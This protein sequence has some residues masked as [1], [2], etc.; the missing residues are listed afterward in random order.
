MVNRN[1]IYLSYGNESEYRRTIFSILSYFSWCPDLIASTR[2]ILYTDAPEYFRSF[3]SEK[4]IE[5]C[6]LSPELLTEMKGPE[7]FIHR[8]KVMVINLSFNSYPNEDQLF[9][10]S[11]TFFT[12][13]ATEIIDTI[14]SGSSLMHVREYTIQDSLRIFSLFKQSQ[15][16]KSFLHYISSNVFRVGNEKISFD[17]RAYSWNSGVLGLH[18]DF[19]MYMPDVVKLTD[20]FYA[21]SK[22]FISE[23]LAFSFILQKTTVISAAKKYITHYWGRRQK[24]LIE[25]LLSSIFEEK[26]KPELKSTEYIRQLT[27]Q[28]KKKIDNDIN[29]EQAVISISRKEWYSAFKKIVKI[30]L[31]NPFD[32]TMYLT[33]IKELKDKKNFVTES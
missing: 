32:F 22:W 29:V 17:N 19:S 12:A 26:Y 27:L 18:K 25:E 21:N 30:T 6:F 8:I 23:Q 13:N 5:Y 9:I 3:L 7:Q 11:D 28:W 20:L 2:I 4:Q 31:R 1:L 15:F 24:V 16:P 10:D 33:I 14:A